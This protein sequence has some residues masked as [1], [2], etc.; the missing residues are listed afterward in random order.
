MHIWSCIPK[1]I[2]RVDL[3]QRPV[4]EFNKLSAKWMVRQ[5]VKKREKDCCKDC[6][7][8]FKQPGRWK[9]PMKG[10]SWKFG[11][12]MPEKHLRCFY[13]KGEICLRTLLKQLKAEVAKPDALLPTLASID[14]WILFSPSFLPLDLDWYCCPI[15]LIWFFSRSSHC[16]I[17]FSA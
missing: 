14:F 7:R 16:C 9:H 15:L 13:L 12:S 5:V 3:E 4:N 6:L 10:G 8:L 17:F 11:C 1:R 2:Y